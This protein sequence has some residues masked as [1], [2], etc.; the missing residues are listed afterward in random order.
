MANYFHNSASPTPKTT[1]YCCSLLCVS[2]YKFYSICRVSKTC[3]SIQY[4]AKGY[5]LLVVVSHQPAGN[6]V[7]P[8]H[9]LTGKG[10]F[11][12]D[13]QNVDAPVKSPSQKPGSCLPL[14][15]TAWS[16][17]P[18]WKPASTT[19]FLPRWLILQIAVWG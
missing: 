6:S 13:W 1:W 18:H 9:S 16:W 8:F 10:G 2:I 4:R 19:R 5:S 17:E 12:S 7:V 15:F 11:T 14:F 3:K